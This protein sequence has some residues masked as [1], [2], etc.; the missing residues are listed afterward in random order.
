M[1]VVAKKGMEDV[2]KKVFEKWDL[3]CTQIGEVTEGD[4]L[5]YYMHGELVADI[6]AESLVLGGGAPIYTREY[7]EPAYVKEISEVAAAV[8]GCSLGELSNAT[9]A[10]A[11]LFFRELS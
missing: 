5:Q 2:V 10:T 6:P 7:K 1:L 11:S 9:C 4:R 8:K 3:N